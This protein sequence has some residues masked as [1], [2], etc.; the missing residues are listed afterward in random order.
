MRTAKQDIKSAIAESLKAFGKGSLRTNATQ[1]YNTL[2]YASE[3]TV[4]LSPNTPENF[5]NEVDQHNRFQKEKALFSKWKS[6][7]FIFQI[8]GEEIKATESGQFS[9]QFDSHQKID[10]RIIESYLFLAIKLRKGHY[11]RTDL[12]TITREINKL[13]P[14]PVLILFQNGDTLT[15][16]VINRRLH[17]RD[18]SRDVLEKVTLIKD[19]R[20]ADPHR[21]HIEILFDLSFGNLYDRYRFSNFVALHDAWQKTLDINELNKRFY[22]EIANWYFWAIKKV[23]FPSQNEIKDID[24]RNATNVIRLITRLIFVWFV[25]EKGL[26]PDDLF[27]LRKLQELLKDLSPDKSSYYKAILQNLFFATLNQEMNTP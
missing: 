19:I 21:A 6:V 10:N 18:Q 23:A 5:L 2:G 9:L 8:T 24:I 16:S 11:T 27:S 12:S 13:F 20:F 17:K 25:K 26:V 7:D 14:M 22:K 4:E 3:K 15:L 1:L